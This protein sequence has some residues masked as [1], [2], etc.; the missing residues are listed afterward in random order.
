MAIGWIP[1]V[2]AD[3]ACRFGHIPQPFTNENTRPTARTFPA[4]MEKNRTVQLGSST[5]VH[6]PRDRFNLT[7]ID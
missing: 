5:L 2:L 7:S 4:T 6:R 3:R 1:T